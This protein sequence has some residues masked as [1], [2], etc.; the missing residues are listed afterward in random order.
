[1]PAEDPQPPPQ[2]QQPHQTAAP[3]AGHNARL[4]LWLFALYFALYA[5]FVGLV[6]YDYRI[7]GRT[8]ALGLNLAVVYG[9]GLIVAAFVL[10][11]VYAALARD[12]A[13]EGMRDEG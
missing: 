7:M 4:G 8:V 11:L 12:D 13:E 9:L 10:A 6:A 2:Q 1:M 5:G 3:A